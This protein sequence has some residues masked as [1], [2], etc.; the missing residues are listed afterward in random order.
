MVRLAEQIRQSCE[1]ENI[2]RRFD[3]GNGSVE[4]VVFS[5]VAFLVVVVVA[6]AGRDK[7]VEQESEGKDIIEAEGSIV[8]VVKLEET[9]ELDKFYIAI[10]TALDK[11]FICL[12]T[13]KTDEVRAAKEGDKVEFSYFQADGGDYKILTF[14]ILS[15]SAGDLS[16]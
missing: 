2:M 11:I 5:A 4:I 16:E 10:D 9:L 14:K 12:A 8:R 13:Q 15:V 3:R 6:L 1:L 7:K